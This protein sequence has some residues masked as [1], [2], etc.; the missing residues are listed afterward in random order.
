MLFTRC[1]HCSTTFRITAEVLN[2]ADGQVRCGRC[3]SIFNAYAEL[4]EEADDEAGRAERAAEPEPQEDTDALDEPAAP[5]AEDAIATAEAARAEPDAESANAA[6]DEVAASPADA[7]R[8]T[9][10]ASA[11]EAR[12]GVVARRHEPLWPPADSDS[13]TRSGSS[14]LWSIATILALVALLSQ[15]AHHFRAE[16]AS[17]PWI[18]PLVQNAYAFLGT[19]IVARG[20]IEQYRVVDWLATAESGPRG[21]ATLA[22]SARIQNRGPDAQPFPHVLVQLKDRWESAI[23]SRVFTPVEYLPSAPREGALMAPGDTA[24]AELMLVDP[25]PD[26]YGF[27]ID[28]CVELGE[29]QLRC[30]TDRVFQ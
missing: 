13:A 11:D 27:E 9:E 18:G 21:Q 7:E 30:A 19:P 8:A 15:V 28:V 17:Q 29:Q 20:D 14:A 12:A 23:G 25:G 4:R 26:A 22:I 3:T 1:P 24:N 6:A 16:V 2:K 10:E 5:A